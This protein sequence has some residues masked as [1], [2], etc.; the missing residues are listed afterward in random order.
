M[1]WKSQVRGRNLK[2]TKLSAE[3]MERLYGAPNTGRAAVEAEMESINE[4]RMMGKSNL[5]EWE[6]EAT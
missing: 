5:E 1:A 4:E 3:E 2:V 6:L